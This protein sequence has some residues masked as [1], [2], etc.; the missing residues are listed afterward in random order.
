MAAF[1][2]VDGSNGIDSEPVGNVLGDGVINFLLDFF[3]TT[4][5]LISGF[6]W[7]ASFSSSHK[8]CFNKLKEIN[9]TFSLLI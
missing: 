6:A 1:S 4:G 7:S 8:I 2:D 9:W 3:F 5:S